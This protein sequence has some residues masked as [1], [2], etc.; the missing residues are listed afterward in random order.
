M[1][2]RLI[3]RRIAAPVRR[4][5]G[6]EDRLGREISDLDADIRAEP[7]LRNGVIEPLLANE[8][9][10]PT[11]FDLSAVQRL[12]REQFDSGRDHGALLGSLASLGLAHSQLLGG[13]LADVPLYL[14]TAST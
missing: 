12:V 7:E 14:R 1:A 8:C 2:A 10:D 9:L 3:G 11:I 5:A 4:L 6:R 13:N